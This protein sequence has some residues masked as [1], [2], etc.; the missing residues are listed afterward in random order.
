M[1]LF[2]NIITDRGSKYS[3]CGASVTTKEDALSVLKELKKNKK[4]AKATHNTWAVLL[5]DIAP[6]KNDDGEVGAGMVIVRMLER[7]QLFDHMIIVTRWFGGIQL[8]GDRFRRVKDCVNY[9]FDQR[10]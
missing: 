1:K 9:Y 10:T 2:E 3:V 7:E 5:K 8:G 6:L 4:Y